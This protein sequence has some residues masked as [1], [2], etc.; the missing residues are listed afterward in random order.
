MSETTFIFRFTGTNLSPRTVRLGE[1]GDLLASAE[2]TLHAIASEKNNKLDKE[3]LGLSLEEIRHGSL[4]LT[5]NTRLPQ[6]VE[7]AFNTLAGAITTRFIEPIPPKAYPSFDKMLKFIR[8]K[9]A[10]ADL[11]VSNGNDEVIATITPDFKIPK[12]VFI[13]GDTTIYGKVVRVGGVT[14]KVEVKTVSGTTLYCPFD[15]ELA[16]ELGA[17]LYE[18]VGLVGEARW[19]VETGIITRFKVKNIVPYRNSSVVETFAYL[20]ERIGRY[21]DDIGDVDEYISQIRGG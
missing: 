17:L 15:Y 14:P 21:Y 5:I 6:V 19:D 3:T 18:T 2:D 11:I 9:E 1:L 12:D 10:H 20:R 8:R 4:E 16:Q 7:P 13:D